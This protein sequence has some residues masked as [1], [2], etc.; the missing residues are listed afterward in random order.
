MRYT[1]GDSKGGWLAR[2][3][4]GRF[5]V[6]L[7][8][9]L[10]SQKSIFAHSQAAAVKSQQGNNLLALTILSPDSNKIAKA[11]ALA[12]MVANKHVALEELILLALII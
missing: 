9:S 6:G 11:R 1:L 7:P 10:M 4:R 5:G 3:R 2:R 8:P 12:L